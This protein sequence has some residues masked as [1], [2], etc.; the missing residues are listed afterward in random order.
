M[1][2][3]KIKQQI[4]YPGVIGDIESSILVIYGESYHSYVGEFFAPIFDWFEAFLATNPPTV[5]IEYWMTYFNTS[6][7]R[8]LTELLNMVEAHQ[9]LQPIHA[10]VYWYCEPND[11]DMEEA[12]RLLQ[13]ET[14][15]NFSCITLD[16][17]QYRRMTK[18][19][20]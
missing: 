12:G 9:K 5:R 10:D 13:K 16:M 6:S 7:A 18:G 20:D 3:L 4:Y 8:R 11:V 14:K 19:F 15:L 2:N 17:D 1:K